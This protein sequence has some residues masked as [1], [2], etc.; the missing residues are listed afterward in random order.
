[1]SFNFSLFEKMVDV[2][3]VLEWSGAF[4]ALSGSLILASNK[5]KPSITYSI[6]LLSN[7]LYIIYFIHTKQFGLLSLN[8]TGFIINLFGW[9]QWIQKADNLN[10]KLTGVLFNLSLIFFAFSTFYIA[11]F[12]TS[13]SIKNAEWIGSTLGIA[14]AF[15]I[16]SRHKYSFMCWFVWCFSNFALL[17][18]AIYTNQHGLL[19]LQLGFM[20]I[21]VYGTYNWVKQFKLERTVTTEI[22]EATSKT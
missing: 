10:T 13:P 9:Y 4:L 3:T 19:F 8:I 11:A 15:L 21:N 6:W 2:W 18:M 5:F 16:S 1:V 7:I 22:M 20:L 12:L 17:I 14:A